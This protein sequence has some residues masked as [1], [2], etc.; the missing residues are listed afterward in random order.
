MI[1][2][3]FLRHSG[4]FAED[5][6]MRYYFKTSGNIRLSKI[7]LRLMCKNCTK[8]TLEF[9]FS[10]LWAN[11]RQLKEVAI[12]CLIDC[13]FRP[14]LEDK[15]RL[16]QLISDVIGIIA[17]NI[18]ARIAFERD[19]DNFLLE[20]II[21]EI[22]RW[23]KFLF[24][25]LSLTYDSRVIERIR[26]SVEKKTEE[27]FTNAVEMSTML[28][29]ESIR[30]KL[31]S[32]FNVLYDKDRLKELFYLFPGEVPDR[33]KLLEDIIN[34]DYNLLSLWTKACT[35]RS[36]CKIEGNDMAESVTALL[37]SPEELIQ[38]EAAN[39]M[40]RT[41]PELYRSVSG[42]IP[43]S[44]KMRLDNIV[45]GTTDKNEYLFEKLHFLTKYFKGIT[46]DDLLPVACELQYSKNFEKDFPG[47]SGGHIIWVRDGYRQRNEVHI[48]Y[49]GVIDG[50]ARTFETGQHLTFYFLPLDA[51]EEYHFQYP[52]NSYEILK[53]IE[54]SEE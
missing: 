18:S 31:I 50:L 7:V 42:R 20:K 53:F 10:R 2:P 38:E 13:K 6:L 14:S 39:L 17:W 24:D 51:V 30:S 36:I 25:L 26:E 16:N 9:L 28:V 52:D 11:S 3:K 37:F 15:Q 4:D 54:S 19:E 45:N 29:S 47:S 27:S 12:K 32:L 21:R 40:A 8:E 33:K 22:D 23:Y 46:E 48:V 34:C 35:L 43:D 41:D 44:M 5:V 49:D 1:L